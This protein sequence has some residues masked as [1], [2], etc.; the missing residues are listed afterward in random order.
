MIAGAW[1]STRAQ[2][3]GASLSQGLGR[4]DAQD[5]SEK[6][7][8]HFHIIRN[9]RRMR[10]AREAKVFVPASR[11]GEG[12]SWALLQA[13]R[14]HRFVALASVPLMIEVEAVLFR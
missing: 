13:L 7:R 6:R 10:V 14:R 11:S 5:L 8:E 9:M 4:G 12:A 1:C 2:I 3:F